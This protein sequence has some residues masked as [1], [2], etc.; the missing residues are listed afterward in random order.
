MLS[1]QSSRGV[2]LTPARAGF[3]GSP[4]PPRSLPDWLASGSGNSTV[5][6]SK[7]WLDA[8]S[9]LRGAVLH[10]P[11][12]QNVSSRQASAGNPLP[13]IPLHS[14]VSYCTVLYQT[15]F[16]QLNPHSKED[17]KLGA[18]RNRKFQHV[19]YWEGLNHENESTGLSPSLAR[20]SNLFTITVHCAHFFIV[21]CFAQDIG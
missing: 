14:I 13:S 2:P 1:Q 5:S 19:V 17:H 6:C 9:T 12:S 15:R 21:G 7:T 11:K 4:F 16:I 8:G 3:L 18:R 10:A 20:S